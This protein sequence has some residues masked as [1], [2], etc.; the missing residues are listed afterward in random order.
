MK[1]LHIT[2]LLTL[3]FIATTAFG[4]S[5]S[6]YRQ[7]FEAF[8]KSP[9]YEAIFN[10]DAPGALSSIQA[11]IEN[12]TQ[13]TRFNR[14]VR[15]I[16]LLLDPIVISPKTMPTLY[17]YVDAMCKKQSITTPTIFI[18]RDV[19][20]KQGF[21][22]A[23]ATKLL[24]SSGAVIIGQKLLLETTDA[25]LE[26]VVAHEIGHISYNHVN[27]DLLITI[28]SLIATNVSMNYFYSTPN[29]TIGD[30]ITRKYAATFMGLCMSRL[31]VNKRFEKQADEFAYKT[32]GKSKGCL[33]LFEDFKNRE[34]TYDNYFGKTYNIL[35]ESKKDLGWYDSIDLTIDYYCASFGNKMDHLFNWLYHNTPLG[36]HPSHDARIKAVND[37][38]ASQE[39][40]AI[41]Q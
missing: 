13:L 3:T 31:I 22:N 9:R 26:A 28:L 19:T 29:D 14:F 15:F 32:M 25:E 18:T 8:K 38:L 39:Q 27:K 36:A 5:T 1:R 21:F 40:A 11:R 20:W 37:Y 12:D 16:F 10:E 4:E 2:S 33:E 30:V 17:A 6:T 23:A 41:Q 34:K 7:E 35:Q 24:M